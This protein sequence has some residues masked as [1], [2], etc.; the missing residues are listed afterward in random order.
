MRLPPRSVARPVLSRRR[1][2]VPRMRESPT[3]LSCSRLWVLTWRLPASSSRTSRRT[4]RWRTC[5]SSSTSPTTPPS[6]ASSPRVSPS[7]PQSTSPTSATS[8]SSS[9]SPTCPPTLT[10]FV[11]CRLRARRC[12]V[13]VATPVTCIR[14]WRRSTSVPGVWRGATGP[15]L[16]SLCSR[17]PTTTSP[18][19]SP[20]SRG[21]SRRARCTSTG[22]CTTGRCTRRST[23]CRRSRA[24]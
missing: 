24:S 22:I 1:Q 11:R 12:R 5:A 8:T 6:S 16:R 7:P 21:T 3:S 18:I 4:A 14:I 20:T 15:S 9:S 23:C 13:A 17:C 2:R 10:P 19:P